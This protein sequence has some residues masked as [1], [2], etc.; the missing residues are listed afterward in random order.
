MLKRFMYGSLG[1]LAIALA[2][3]LGHSNAH[4]FGLDCVEAI[5]FYGPGDFA[6]VV[7]G[8]LQIWQPSGLYEE[9]PALPSGSAAA[10]IYRD[11]GNPWV[12]LRNGRLYQWGPSPSWELRQDVMCGVT[13]AQPS[14]WGQ[15]KHRAGQ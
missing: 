2:F 14:T 3:Q 9:F 12:M 1:V 7:N 8:V 4:S 5:T 13:A 15:I 6:I 11:G 10:A